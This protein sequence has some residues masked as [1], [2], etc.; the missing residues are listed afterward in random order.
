MQTAL[1]ALA[2]VAISYGIPHQTLN[3]MN[4]QAFFNEAKHYAPIKGK[5]NSDSRI[6]M[7]TGLSRRDV[8]QLREEGPA[9]PPKPNLNWLISRQWSSLPQFLDE[10]GKK[11]PLPRTRHMGGEVSWEALVESLCQEVRPRTVLDEWLR[12]QLAVLDEQDRV[13]STDDCSHVKRQGNHIATLRIAA[14][15]VYEAMSIAQRPAQFQHQ[16]PVSGLLSCDYGHNMTRES[17]QQVF[18]AASRQIMPIL[19]ELNRTIVEFE[20]LD[21]GKDDA[22]HR[23]FLGTALRYIT[24]DG[25]PMLM[26]DEANS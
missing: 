11:K 9:E 12:L 14:Q 21:A 26:L 16:A 17:A 7:L 10:H 19:D 1:R 6:A 4:K 15:M 2:R 23:V 18:L 5:P 8:R 13:V 24:M 3:S 20:T 22:I 25:E